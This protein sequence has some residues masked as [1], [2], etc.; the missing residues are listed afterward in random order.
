M[1]YSAFIL[2]LDSMNLKI[3]VTGGA[4][5]IGSNTCIELLENGF[6][7]TVIDNFSN[8]SLESLQRVERISGKKITVQKGDICDFSFLEQVISNNEFD[9]V[10]HFAGLK[11]VGESVVEPIKYYENNVTGT[12]SLIKA[13]DNANIKNLIFSSS[14]TVY[15]IPE[16]LPIHE[17]V[18]RSAT[19]PYGQSKLMIEYMLEDL[20]ISDFK[21]NIVSLRYFNPVGAH[22]SGLIG[23]DPKDIP[24]NIMPYISQVAIGK[25]E[26][27]NIFGSDYPTVDGTG[28]RD[29]IHVTDLAKGHLSALNYIFLHEQVGFLPF[30][31]GRGEGISVLELLKEFQDVS[32][33]SIPYQ[34]VDKRPGDVAEC[35]ADPTRANK[36]LGWK[37]KLGVKEMCEDAWRWQK[38]NPNGY[39]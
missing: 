10:I 17:A 38:N 4:G 3:L 14:A 37:A 1:I 32:G 7:V 5:Y 30:N 23:E 24:G 11:A 39:C 2:R 28:I 33:R 18:T 22:K 21:W 34:M 36:Y 9:A 6:D 8:S 19:N 13:M 25:R 29:Y 27:L 15:G 20:A 31:L 12:I 16:I 26:K 35:Y